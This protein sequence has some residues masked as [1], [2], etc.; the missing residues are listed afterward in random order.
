MDF[1]RTKLAAD[2][3][4]FAGVNWAMRMLAALRGER[5]RFSLR[6]NA[7]LQGIHAGKRC[8][9][10]GNSPTVKEQNLRLLRDEIT[11]FVNRAFLHPDYEYI[12]PSYHIFIDPK[13]KTGVW[14]L[15]FLDEARDR[16]PDVTFLLNARWF[17]EPQF[18]PLKEKFR[19]YWLN[20]RLFCTAW[21]RRKVD[22]TKLTLGGAVAEQGIIAGMYMGCRQIYFTGVEGNGLGYLIVDRPS[23]CYG[24][25]P[26]DL[27]MDMG[28]LS[29]SFYRA[30]QSFR[31]WCDLAA[32][33]Q[34]QGVSVKNC[35]RGGV[36]DAFPRV[37]FESLF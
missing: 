19:I 33:A 15:S 31:R 14:P 23:H 36:I 4:F 12:A 11:F 26:E 18:Q 25:N 28:D 35:T 16:N 8:F 27:K 24:T 9:V 5:R 13:L 2:D 6:R 17:N 34:R 30:S 1:W 20:T 37:T 22:L 3:F 21:T 32:Y 10:V 29:L 7:E